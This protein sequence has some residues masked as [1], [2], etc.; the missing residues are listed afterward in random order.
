MQLVGV[1]FSHFAKFA[2]GRAKFALVSTNLCQTLPNLCFF[3]EKVVFNR[4]DC[5]PLLGLLTLLRYSIATGG[6]SIATGRVPIRWR[7]FLFLK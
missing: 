1:L 4:C 6:G 3:S 7:G 5:I 2:L